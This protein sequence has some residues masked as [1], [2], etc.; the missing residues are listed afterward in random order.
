MPRTMYDAVTP[1]NIPADATLVAAYVDG[2]YATSYADLVAR[3]PHA[4]H[5]SICAFDTGVADVLDCEPGNASPNQAVD[6]VLTMRELG[7]TP[8]VYCNE[9]DPTWGWPALRSAFDAAHVPQPL[10][11]TANYSRPPAIMPGTIGHQYA[12]SVPPGYDVS[13]MADNW[14]P[15]LDGWLTMLTDAEQAES[16]GVLHDLRTNGV[17][18]GTKSAGETLRTAVTVG[19]STYNLTAHVL[20]HLSALQSA[21]A[22]ATPGVDMTAVQ[23][24]AKAGAEAALAGITLT[25]TPTP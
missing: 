16:Y 7:R 5:V 11:W 17:A 15:S 9:L 13:I 23:A 25:V 24:A 8:T 14:P 3:F 21:I 20:A 19:Q 22:A 1:A 12:G 18:G 2:R 6:W 4:Q 10:Y